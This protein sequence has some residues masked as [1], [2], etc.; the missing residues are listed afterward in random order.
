M[1]YGADFAAADPANAPLDAPI[2][3]G[4]GKPGIADLGLTA[5]A[6]AHGRWRRTDFR[7]LGNDTVERYERC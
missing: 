6:D 1:S 4:A 5:L 7:Q 3:I 2:L